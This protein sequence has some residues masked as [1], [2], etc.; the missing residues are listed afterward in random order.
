MGILNDYTIHNWLS[1]E[2]CLGFFFKL[3]NINLK[4]LKIKKYV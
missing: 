2:Y 3:L 4:Y 1:L